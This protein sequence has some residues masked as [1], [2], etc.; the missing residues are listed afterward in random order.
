MGYRVRSAAFA[1]VFLVIG[2]YLW[3]RQAG[4]TAF[5]LLALQ[6]VLYPQLVYAAVRRA[7]RQNQ[8]ELLAQ[9]LDALVF[10][11]WT[12]ALGFPTWIAYATCMGTALNAAVAQGLP[13]VAYTLAVYGLGMLGWIVFGGASYLGGYSTLVTAMCFFGS[14]AYAVVIGCVVHELN[15]KLQALTRGRG[16]ADPA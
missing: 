14:M 3:E 1:Y 13:R 16:P 15:R 5:V 2:V 4:P 10:G 6:F 9:Y 11:I 12:A 8:A 7:R